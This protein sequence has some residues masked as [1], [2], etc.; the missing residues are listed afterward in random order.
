MRFKDSQNLRKL[1]V[2]L[3][4]KNAQLEDPEIILFILSSRGKKSRSW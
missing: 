4:E 2:M 3:L 1:V